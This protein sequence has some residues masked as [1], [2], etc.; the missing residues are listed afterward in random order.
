MN[1]CTDRPQNDVYFMMQALVVASRAGC[2][3][4]RVGC[5]LVND[6][7]HVLATGYNGP[8]RGRPPC[9]MAHCPGLMAKSGS[10]LDGCMAIHAE[11][12]A[13]LQCRNVQEIHTAYV[14]AAPCV[15]CTK[16]LL[17]TG[18]RRIVFLTPYPH[19]EAQ[20]VWTEDLREWTELSNQQ[21]LE[22]GDKFKELS[23]V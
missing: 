21:A 20:R 1:S 22:I 8:A 3:R 14:T 6:M 17:N 11:Q 12:N 2:Q 7:N 10:S 9:G 13:L 16:L 23:Y 18:C 15:T 5:V 4:R 19:P